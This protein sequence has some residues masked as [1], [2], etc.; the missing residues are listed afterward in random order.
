VVFRSSE[1]T[2]VVTA[3][4]Q[5]V[6][7]YTDEPQRSGRMGRS[8]AQGRARRGDQCPLTIWLDMDATGTT[9]SGAATESTS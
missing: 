5:L 8:P 7:T 2:N 1:Y 6:I 4:P 3:T 9:P